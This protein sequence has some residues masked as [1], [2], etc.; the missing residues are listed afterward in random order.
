MIAAIKAP[1]AQY[2]SEWALTLIFRSTIFLNIN[3]IKTPKL[4]N[5]YFTAIKA[6]GPAL[7]Q[8]AI[9]GFVSY[10]P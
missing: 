5:A 6:S 3:R 2:N 1:I 8:Y 10:A 9:K 7:R 4:V